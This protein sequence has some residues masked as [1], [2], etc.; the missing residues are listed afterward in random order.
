MYIINRKEDT[1]C[2][3]FSNVIDHFVERLIRCVPWN[4]L[5]TLFED[6]HCFIVKLS[7]SGGR[8]NTANPREV[9]LLEPPGVAFSSVSLDSCVTASERNVP[10]HRGFCRTTVSHQSPWLLPRSVSQDSSSPA[11]FLDSSPQV[12]TCHLWF[13]TFMTCCLHWTLCLGL[14]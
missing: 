8:K 7:S 6:K 11:P 14:W 2:S 5:K 10:C 12:F 9:S 1:M 4:R 3:I 13:S